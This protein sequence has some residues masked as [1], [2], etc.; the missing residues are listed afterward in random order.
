MGR[1]DTRGHHVH[2][3][4]L[5]SRLVELEARNIRRD[6]VGSLT[7]ESFNMG[8]PIDGVHL[9]EGIPLDIVQVGVRLA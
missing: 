3:V 8:A 6:F 9:L 5:E 4:T 1:G 7:K 2:D